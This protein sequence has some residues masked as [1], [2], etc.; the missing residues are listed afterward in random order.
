MFAFTH[1]D[2]IQFTVTKKNEANPKKIFVC[3]CLLEYFH[4]GQVQNVVR[5][6]VF[7]YERKSEDIK[8]K[9]RHGISSYEFDSLD[10]K[11]KNSK[12]Q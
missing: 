2:Y 8:Y 9:K 10:N 7:C 4:V 5:E 12:Q 1:K 6:I 3:C 11:K